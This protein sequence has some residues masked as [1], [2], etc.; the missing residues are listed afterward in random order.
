MLSLHRRNTSTRMPVQAFQIPSQP[1]NLIVARGRMIEQYLENLGR[2]RIGIFREYPYLYDGDMEYE[3]HYLSRYCSTEHSILLLLND[4][5]DIAAACTGLPMKYEEPAIQAPF[6]GD[7]LDL[8]YIGEIMVRRDC[9]S[10][11][12]GSG[13]VS[14][15]IR[16]IDRTRYSRTCIYT[17]ERP[18]NHPARPIPY[19]S[20]D[21]LWN[22]LGFVK[23]P[24]LKV[25]YPWKELG[26]D[27]ETEKPMNV[28]IKHL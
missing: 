17:V 24:I 13:L 21:S 2:F 1:S 26:E 18:P 15:M 7:C 22:S 9:R 8:F 5:Q 16:M 25:Y 19:R 6:Q 4:G 3:R 14:R 11:G 23:S 10:M 20:P 28:W 27:K 12:I